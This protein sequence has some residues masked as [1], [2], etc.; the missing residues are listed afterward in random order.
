LVSVDPERRRIEYRVENPGWFPQLYP[1]HT[2]RGRVSFRTEG[3]C[4]LGGDNNGDED[5][6]D[7]GGAVVL[8]WRVEVRPHKPAARW[9]KAFTTAVVE[10]ITR[11]LVVH[12]RDPSAV[13]RVSPPRGWKGRSFASVRKDSWLGGVLD[14]HLN[15]S[16]STWEQTLSLFQPWTWGRATDDE[17]SASTAWA[18]G[19]L[20]D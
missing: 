19:R 15:D 1:V 20:D 12:L 3:E 8:E 4:R 17:G 14:A 10:R 13:V 16:R 5:D 2:H 9:V 11:N 18:V 6:G 7:D